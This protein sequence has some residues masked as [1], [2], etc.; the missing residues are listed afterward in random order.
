M[1]DIECVARSNNL[2]GENPIWNVAEQAL[3]WLDTKTPF[4]RRFH[5]GSGRLDQWEVP[6]PYNRDDQ[7][8]SFAFR[9]SGG[10]IAAFRRG[11]HALDIER[12]LV[13]PIVDAE[14]VPEV[15]ESNRMND[16]KC[17]A[18]GRYWCG[19]MNTNYTDPTGSLYRLGADLN[20]TRMDS[21][22]I[23]SNGIAFSPDNKTMYYADTRGF[24]IWAYDFD[25]DDGVVRNRREF[26][27][28]RH[29]AG[30]P[31]G[32]TV[33]TDGNY[34]I[35][36]IAMGTVA[37]FN[38][39]GKLE[40]LIELPVTHPTM[41]AFGGSHMDTLFV[42]SASFSL[43]PE[44]KHKQPL[45]GALFAISGIGAQGMPEPLFEG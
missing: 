30:R 12:G 4:V 9:R 38:P 19:S 18:R 33:D 36:M 24:M 35:A 28:T 6:A 41:C 42:T 29:F 11:F 8:V 5:P 40:R 45:A 31:D 21:G 17:D 1:P 15:P 32:A 14:R 10:M 25:L 13:Q 43:T 20:C 23:C 27:S 2:I 39:E 22:I 37:K 34:W 26:V 44:Q 16:G 3:Y 7:L